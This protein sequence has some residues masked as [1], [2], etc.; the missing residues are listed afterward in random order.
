MKFFSAVLVALCALAAVS[1]QTAQPSFASNIAVA[2]RTLNRFQNRLL[3][4][5]RR[6]NMNRMR[7]AISRDMPSARTR[8]SP[9]ESSLV[10]PGTSRSPL[11]G[12]QLETLSLP[13]TLPLTL[14]YSSSSPLAGSE[15]DNGKASESHGKKIQAPRGTIRSQI[16]SPL[17]MSARTL[18]AQQLPDQKAKFTVLLTKNHVENVEQPIL[19]RVVQPY[20][21]RIVRQ[22]VPQVQPYNTR[23]IQPV[24]QQ[25]IQPVL[26]TTVETAKPAQLSYLQPIQNADVVLAPRTSST[27]KPLISAAPRVTGKKH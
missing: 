11:E 2:P 10:T 8:T 25:E 23:V 7:E 20:H 15:G 16:A 5:E 18:E 26:S 4:L 3:D 21:Q 17:T 22:P 12:L 27:I 13:L 6:A 1:A 14:P 9:I 19:Q 24:V